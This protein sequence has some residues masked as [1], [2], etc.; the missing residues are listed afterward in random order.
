MSAVLPIQAPDPGCGVVDLGCQTQSAFERII[1]DVAHGA[2]DLVVSMTGWWTTTS[3]IDPTDPAVVAAQGVTRPLILIILVASVLVQSIRIILSRKGEPLIMVAS[4]LLR[5]A[6]VSALGL[7]VLQVALRAGDDL[8]AHLLDNAVDNY[9]QLMRRTLL[10]A[11][12]TFVVLLMSLIAAVL[13]LVQW[14]LMAMRQAGLLVLAAML[15]L[16]ASGS[17]NRATRGWLD[18][19][20]AWVV[21]MVVYKPAAAFIYYIGYSYL[22]T[23]TAPAAP[24]NVATMITG[25]MVLLLAVVAM[26]VLLKFFA[27]SGTQ[28]GGG[29]GGG[30]GFLGAA[31]AV[32]MSQGYGRGGSV[33]RAATMQNSGPGSAA[34]AGQHTAPAG[35][36]STAGTQT[37]TGAG[38]AS[39]AAAAAGPAAAVVAAGLAARSAVRG[40]AGR[41]TDGADGGGPA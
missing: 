23:T 24:A 17:L 21:A 10:D 1:T 29:N 36:A 26:P 39:G 28:I 25:L 31:G 27:W 33:D 34:T 19:L 7:V 37:A 8:A 32:A 5:Y 30:S 15:P 3:S 22:S 9:A 14:V 13:S 6:A 16:A 35:A 41:M 40:A 11:N 38:S 2:A 18:R 20:L 4:G 12:A